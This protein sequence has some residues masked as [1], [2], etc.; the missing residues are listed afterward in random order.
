MWITIFSFYLEYVIFCFYYIYDYYTYIE[1]H[2]RKVAARTVAPD[3]P[4]APLSLHP[5]SRARMAV[6]E[7]LR[8][9]VLD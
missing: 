9:N 6:P 7:W 4:R 2:D 3:R 5:N 1:F 8:P